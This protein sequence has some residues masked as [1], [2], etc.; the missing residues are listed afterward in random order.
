MS[1]RK[2][3]QISGATLGYITG[4]VRGAV[5]G[6]KAAGAA[7]DYW[8]TPKNLP[9]NSMPPVTPTNRRGSTSSSH[10]SRRMSI[11][12]GWPRRRV[13]STP[14]SSHVRTP[15]RVLFG[16]RK[17]AFRSGGTTVAQS[18]VKVTGTVA[19]TGKKRKVK[20]SKMLRK[21]IKAVL[22]TKGPTG[23]VMETIPRQV[24]Y[25]NDNAQTIFRA[26]DLQCNSKY[27]WGFTPTH[28]YQH[29][30]VLW[31]KQ[32]WPAYRQDN[33]DLGLMNQYSPNTRIEVVNSYYVV[34]LKNN[35]GRVI[36]VKLWD[37]QPKS[38][39]ENAANADINTFVTNEL[40]R[41]QYNTSSDANN[42]RGAENPTSMNQYAIG[43][44]PNMLTSVRA[45][46]KMQETIINLEP[47]KEYYHKVQG[48]QNF[49]LNFQKFYQ[50]GNLYNPIQKFCK[51]T[52]IALYTDLAVD[53]L[54]LQSGR[55]TE[56][57]P[58]QPYG[59]ACETEY[60]TKLKCPDQTGWINHKTDSTFADSAVINNTAKGYAFA[61]K[62]WYTTQ[63]GVTI[64]RDDNNPIE[65]A[66]S[67]GI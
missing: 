48:P 16:R 46:F 51:A 59:V 3:A 15:R 39:W 36:T 55:W 58:E 40:V 4:D 22:A 13:A 21:K 1:K 11:D 62:N 65:N 17:V 52:L 19:K 57:S 8:H 18:A 38:V 54:G 23:F 66:S 30:A 63:S 60:Y 28:F 20:V 44:R 25:V 31:A 67:T 64:H 6:Y 24:M 14:A 29:A 26:S 37:F 49:M 2:I 53:T 9:K 33:R 35:S 43:F 27:N 12:S 10:S 7:Y 34:K 5:A 32:S 45:L 41:T 50:D 42:Q 61:I 47:G 56:M